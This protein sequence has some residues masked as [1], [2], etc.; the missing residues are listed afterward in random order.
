MD[1]VYNSSTE[2]AKARG[3]LKVKTFQDYVIELW[4]SLDCIVKIHPKKK[5]PKQ[6]ISKQNKT[7]QESGI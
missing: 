2:E 6:R 1:D 3:W 7:K 4:A 5:N